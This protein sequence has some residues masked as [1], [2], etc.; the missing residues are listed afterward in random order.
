[1]QSIFF[2]KSSSQLCIA[3]SSGKL[4]MKFGGKAVTVAV[5]D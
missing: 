1:M 3:I 4:G 5:K 2:Y